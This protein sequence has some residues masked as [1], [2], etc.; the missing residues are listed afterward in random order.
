MSVKERA[1]KPTITE[2]TLGQL[3]G[4]GNFS[5]IVTAVHNATQEMFALKV[6]E[7]QRVKRLRIR[8]PNIFNE[9]NME[10]EVLNRLRHPNIIRLYQT[11]QDDDN[12]YFLL[13]YLSGGELLDR[14]LFEGRQV[15]L[16]EEAARFY[17]ADMLN[18]VEYLHAQQLVHRDLKPENMVVSK[19]D[20]HLRLVDF[21]TA[22]NMADTTL[23]GP[24]FVGTPE[25]MS[26]ET[27][28]N[29]SVSYASDIWALGCITFQLLTGETPFSGGSAYLTFLRVQEGTFIMPEFLSD[30]AKDLVTQLLKKNPEERLGSGGNG[31]RDIKAH[32]F[33]RGI[34]FD[35][36]MSVPPPTLV[37]HNEHFFK[38]V[39]DIESAESAR[40]TDVELS[41]SG[42]SLQT[43]VNEMSD[44]DKSLLMH[45]LKRKQILHFPGWKLP[46]YANA[47]TPGSLRLHFMDVNRMYTGFTHE[48]QNHW[49][50]DFSYLV[51]PGPRLGKESANRENDAKGGSSWTTE[52]EAFAKTL[53]TVNE[54]SPAFV[55]ICGDFVNAR[56]EEC[57]HVAQME[58]FQALLGRIR[59]DIRLVFLPG[60]DVFGG[61]APTIPTIAAYTQRFGED[62]YSFWYG[63][64]KFIVMNSTLLLQ[65]EPMADQCREQ[66]AWLKKELENG[67]MCARGMCVL[68]Y[69]EFT[70][71]ASPDG[72]SGKLVFDNDGIPS[73][74]KHDYERL[75]A[76]P[77]SCL[78]V[79]T[80][81]R[82]KQNYKPR[83]I[84]TAK[85]GES[86]ENGD[87]DENKTDV[88]VCQRRDTT[89]APVVHV[90]SVAQTGFTV[91][92]RDVVSADH[93]VKQ[94]PTPE[95]MEDAISHVEIA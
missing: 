5:R 25:Y 37:L 76:S 59:S 64:I 69:H 68:S 42:D 7:K 95:E 22:K 58:A 11:F 73:E 13:E 72:K 74:V 67:K 28:D 34:D 52:A 65:K 54:A 79:C 30:E 41:T 21:G 39:K 23:N 16:N 31:M 48:L 71:P 15:G 82:S 77:K 26:P 88:L 85:P 17:L 55:I 6:I 83:Q 80:S 3:M 20:G 61:R 89:T 93:E 86:Q 81:N 50:K 40:A 32:P 1:E 35:N 4:E 9:I 92:S 24:N 38:L 19:D 27:I 70:V 90:V 47:F 78:I 91:T 62:Y 2:F 46:I 63:G 60:P 57:Y 14:L 8:H 33:F 45:L 18:A 66:E 84:K 44:K 75:L 51:I 10:K 12:L 36:H 49:V 43:F 29:K 53:A 56:P 94:L 87:D